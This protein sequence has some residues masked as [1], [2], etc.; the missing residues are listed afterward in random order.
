MARTAASTAAVLWGARLSHR[1]VCSGI[2]RTD[3]LL[4]VGQERLPV[5]RPVEDGRGDDAVGAQPG[6]VGG[7]LPV[8]VRRGGDQAFAQPGAPVEPRHVGLGRRLVEEDELRGVHQPLDEPAEVAAP[9]RHV[10]A[11]HLVGDEA[12]FERQVEMRQHPVDARLSDLGAA[13]RDDLVGDLLQ[14]QIRPL[15]F[16]A[17]FTQAASPRFNSALAF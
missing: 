5:H 16:G 2:Q 13:A 6:D 1:T 11:R 3:A 8:A 17:S 9:R 7:R 14:R 10:G 12:F 15:D 4:D